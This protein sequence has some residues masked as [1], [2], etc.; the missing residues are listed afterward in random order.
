MLFCA[1]LKNSD[2]RNYISHCL[3]PNINDWS[4]VAGPDPDHVPGPALA[5]VAI[6]LDPGHD[7][8]QDPD[9][10]PQGDHALVLIRGLDPVLPNDHDPARQGS[11][12]PAQSPVLDLV[13]NLALNHG[14]DRPLQENPRRD[15]DQNHQQ[16]RIRWRL[17]M[18]ISLQNAMKMTNKAENRNRT[19]T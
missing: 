2:M 5:A 11:P 3:Y 1:C 13:P 9:L 4:F 17:R 12:D 19:R 18:V 7:H 10:V 16:K 15:L 8:D 6:A 14:R